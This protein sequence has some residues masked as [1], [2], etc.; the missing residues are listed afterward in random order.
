MACVDGASIAAISSMPLAAMPKSGS[1]ILSSGCSIPANAKAENVRA[2]RE[3][4]EEYG[5]Y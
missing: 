2:L 4:V 1:F 5:R 3:A